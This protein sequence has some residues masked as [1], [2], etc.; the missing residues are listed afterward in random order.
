MELNLNS[1][2][3]PDVFSRPASPICQPFVVEALS[4]LAV[5]LSDVQNAIRDL[6]HYLESDEDQH[7]DDSFAA[8]NLDA[9]LDDL[10]DVTRFV[11][12]L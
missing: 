10:L 9:L 12:R 6:V 1:N 11:A 2:L 7:A 8:V 5:L 3:Y 4:D